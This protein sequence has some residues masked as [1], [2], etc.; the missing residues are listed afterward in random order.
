M[1][2][3]AGATRMAIAC[4]LV[5]LG[6]IVPGPATG[7]EGPWVPFVAQRISK[8]YRLSA[9]GKTLIGEESDLW[10]RDDQGSLYLRI[11]PIFG[12]VPGAP[13]VVLLFDATTGST[14]RID[15]RSKT[16]RAQRGG[17]PVAAPLDA[18]SFHSRRPRDR[19]IGRKTILGIECEGW[20]TVWAKSVA[21]PEGGSGGEEWVAPSLNFAPLESVTIDLGIEVDIRMTEI[22]PGAKADPMFFQ[23]PQ[24]FALGKVTP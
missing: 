15:Y 6:V 23:L 12:A 3:R 8:T 16:I 14:Y 22:E 1:R 21:H 19:F 24:G 13:E 20:R 9:T 11:T 5:L 18:E 4:C 7:G 2:A 17:Q 10:L